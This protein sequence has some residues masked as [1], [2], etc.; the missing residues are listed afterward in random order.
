MDFEARWQQCLESLRDSGRMRLLRE[1]V[2]LPGG[3]RQRDGRTLID[4]S[5]NDYLGLAGHP[6]LIAQAQA[7]AAQFGAGST[8]SRLVCGHLPV[9]I[10]KRRL[11]WIRFGSKLAR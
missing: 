7:Y 10:D 6:A 3:R 8:A 9:L 5:S 1:S 4:F 11:I 2:R